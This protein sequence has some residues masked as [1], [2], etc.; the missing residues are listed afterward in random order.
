[1]PSRKVLQKSM[2]AVASDQS[3]QETTSQFYTTD[4]I[5]ELLDVSSRSVWRWIKSCELVAHRF[6]RIVR[7]KDADLA[8]FLAERSARRR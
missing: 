3:R 8:E 2:T 1:M 5:A 4:D 6:G 7:V